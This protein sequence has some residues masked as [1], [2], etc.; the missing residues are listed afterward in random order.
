M[1]PTEVQRIQFRHDTLGNWFTY[2]PILEVG[3]PA[4][5]TDTG[6]IKYGNGVDRWRDLPYAVG[7]AGPAGPTGAPGPAGPSGA[8]GA[9][10]P[11]GPQGPIGP[12]GHPNSLAVGTVTTGPTA[13]AT[14]TGTAPNQTVN[15]V[16]EKGPKGDTGLTGTQG[17]QGPAGPAGP[18]GAVGP[19]GPQGI[20]GPKG[21]AAGINLKGEATAWP[22]ATN[23]VADDL[24][25][26]PYPLPSGTPAGYNPGDGAHYTGVSWINVGPIRGPQGPQGVAGPA[27][28]TGPAGA[29]GPA[30]PEGPEGPRGPTGP[31]GLQGPAGAPNILTV[32]ATI[33]V[34]PSEL[35]HVVVNGSS[36][37][38][39]LDF[40]LPAPYI[41]TMTIG[42]VTEGSPASA[43]ITGTAPN[44]V[45]NLVIPAGG[46]A[47]PT[48]TTIFTINPQSASKIEGESVTFNADATS[49]DG[50]I[51]YS[52]EKSD[53]SGV[54][55]TLISGS[56]N[57]SLTLPSVSLSDNNYLFRCIA[58][59][60]NTQ[61][62][63]VPA[64]L[65]VAAKPPADGTSWEHLYVRSHGLARF[66]N[67]YHYLLPYRS[68]DARTWQPLVG[69]G[70][71]AVEQ[72][73]CLYGNS[74]YYTGYARSTDGVDFVPTHPGSSEWDTT[75]WISFVPFRGGE[76]MITGN[77]VGT[78]RPGDPPPTVTYRAWKMS[79]GFDYYSFTLTGAVIN[80]LKHFP[81]PNMW[82]GIG[83]VT[84]G[85]DYEIM[86][87]PTGA[88]WTTTN[89]RMKAASHPGM[90]DICYCDDPAVPVK[91]VAVGPGNS[92]YTSVDGMTWIRRNLPVGDW[93]AVT[94]GNGRF[95]AIAAN[96][97]AV[98]TSPDGITWSMLLT[99]PEAEN[100]RGLS[101][102]NGFFLASSVYPSST[103]D[104]NIARSG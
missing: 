26:M 34:I 55:W 81:G 77:R 104:K 50:Q 22:P 80:T 61:A 84:E 12:D 63:S 67:G 54:T 53:D 10:G 92:A 2:N 40:Y 86:Y 52:W 75:N 24:W 68:A 11:A 19:A 25:L 15:F 35:P 1:I 72:Q 9:V 47:P 37:N 90:V 48:G 85:S 99:L 76:F 28:S 100:W 41:P 46:S 27:G 36:P 56:G 91:C 17:I 58:T 101:F 7:A 70:S 87:S 96:S 31:Q 14:I 88:V 93:S 59:T 103:L 71:L 57:K 97:K 16:F 43:S 79:N 18:A 30:G 66:G 89:V 49:T 51:V 8:A 42:T 4:Y 73:Q 13:A 64:T 33:P 95:M 102:G 5:E 62:K 74:M 39:S 98:C 3:E 69:I 83:Q 38:Q 78:Y 60:A 29:T 44:F 20:Q 6:K 21:D 65:Q 45:L 94:Y 82:V 32:N 23:P